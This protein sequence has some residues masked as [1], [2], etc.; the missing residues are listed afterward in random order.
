MKTDKI[1]D[2]L[3][4]IKLV[5]VMWKNIKKKVSDFFFEEI[6]IE[7]N[8]EDQIKTTPNRNIS[9]QNRVVNAKVKYEYP[10]KQ[11]APFRFPVIPYE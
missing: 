8:D 2:T 9:D 11:D 3:R 1:E 5:R 6:E 4:C 7:E 10:K